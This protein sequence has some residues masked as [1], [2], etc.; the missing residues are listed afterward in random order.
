MNI[1]LVYRCDVNHNHESMELIGVAKN[2]TQVLSIID[3]AIKHYNDEPLN[4]EAVSD[5]AVIGQTQSYN[6][7]GE[8]YL[9][10]ETMGKLI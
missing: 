8:F 4:I 2:A 6:G 3:Q 9:R 1:I 7:E 10:S 5:L